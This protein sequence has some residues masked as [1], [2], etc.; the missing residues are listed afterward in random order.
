MNSTTSTEQVDLN[1]LGAES[2][3]N[4]FDDMGAYRTLWATESNLM[5]RR[6][7]LVIAVLNR[8]T[9]DIDDGDSESDRLLLDT[10]TVLGAEIAALMS[11][12]NGAGR[13]VVDTAMEA[14]DRLVHVAAL[15]RDGLISVASFREIILQCKAIVDAD[16]MSAIDAEIATDIRESGSVSKSDAASI[17]R[18]HVAEIDP[19]AVRDVRQA[20]GKGVNVS[21]DGDES[22]LTIAADAEQVLLAKKSVDAS[23]AELTCADD[24]RSVGARRADFAIARLT[25]GEFTCDCGNPE[26]PATATDTEVAERFARVVVHVVADASTLNGESDKAG[27]M[28]GYGVIDAHHVREAAA[29]P[30]ATVRPLDMA[31]IADNPA[32]AGNPY[33]PTAATDTAVRAVHG[34]CSVPGCTRAAWSCD[35][36]H[37]TEYNHADP[38][39][40]GATCPCNLAP[41]CRWRIQVASATLRGEEFAVPDRFPWEVRSAVL[42]ALIEGGSG[43]DVS[44]SLNVGLATVH[45]WAHRAGLRYHFGKT[46]GVI[47]MTAGQATGEVKYRRLTLAD[48]SFIEA[49]LACSPPLSMRKIAAELGVAPSTVSREIKTRQQLSY[50]AQPHYHAAAAHY[51]AVADRIR[52][53]VVKLE[54]FGELRNEVVKRL[55][56]RLSPEQVSAELR[57]EFPDDPEMHVSHETIYQALYV[58]GRGALRHELTVE[59]ALRSGRAVRKPRSKLP[60]ATN[61]PWL[62]GARLTDRPAEAADRAIPGHWEGD[63][64]IGSRNSAL[65]SL[66]ERRSRYTLVG[67]LVDNRL[68]LTVAEVLQQMAV[69][70]PDALFS[71]LTWDQGP[72]MSEHAQFTVATDCKVFFC[73][74]HSPWQRPTNENTN[75]LIRDFYPKGTDFNTVSDEDLYEMER[76]LNRRPRK[77]LGWNKPREVLFEDITGVALAT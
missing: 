1:T 67:R 66:V 28:D 57:K 51:A 2:A 76:L 22:V 46:G 44:A 7:Q 49:G 15:L 27:W 12:S 70:V 11:M 20:R 62:E 75:G 3:G 29:R 73:D 23:A 17:A 47:P 31:A 5:W 33:R 4:D 59:K 65:I 39:S 64:V 38:T 16:V 10:E 52:P 63:L 55:N 40:G 19:D 71:T 6:L 18:R 69:R 54:V 25:G 68:A 42:T 34:T 14:R 32:Q 24:S 50:K 30:D 36:D 45:K 8:R 21:H 13:T 9:A 56:D 53:R 60:A 43:R 61:R 26:C 35:L 74:P 72:E 41:K 48:R 58:Q 37:V 77:V